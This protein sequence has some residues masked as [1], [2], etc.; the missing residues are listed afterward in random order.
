MGEDSIAIFNNELDTKSADELQTIFQIQSKEKISEILESTEALYN[1]AYKALDDVTL[2]DYNIKRTATE[3]YESDDFF[4]NTEEIVDAK[5][6]RQ[7]N[8]L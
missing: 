3:F 6:L 2:I 8:E 7:M 5:T 4:Q 1:R